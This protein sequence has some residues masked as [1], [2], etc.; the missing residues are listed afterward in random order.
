MAGGL[1]ESAVTAADTSVTAAQVEDTALDSAQLSPIVQYKS[2]SS[3]VIDEQK[4]IDAAASQASQLLS[5]RDSS[6]EIRGQD[7]DSWP[8]VDPPLEMALHEVEQ[9]ASPTSLFPLQIYLTRCCP[10]AVFW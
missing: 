5:A 3:P 8:L 1:S 6:A 4:L 9:D 10:F 7:L 2:S